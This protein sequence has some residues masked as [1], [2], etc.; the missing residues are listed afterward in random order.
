MTLLIGLSNLREACEG[1]GKFTKVNRNSYFRLLVDYN[2]EALSDRENYAAWK[3][4]HK[5]RG[6]TI[7]IRRLF[8]RK[9]L[10]KYDERGRY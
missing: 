9:L 3:E 1:R 2:M 8:L 5:S 4:F 6:D 7:T 10:E